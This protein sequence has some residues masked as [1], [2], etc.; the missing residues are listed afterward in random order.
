MSE[1]WRLIRIMLESIEEISILKYEIRNEKSYLDQLFIKLL[2]L[3]IL[4]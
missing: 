1:G 4:E 2:Q 3:N